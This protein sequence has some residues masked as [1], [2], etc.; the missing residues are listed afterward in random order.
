MSKRI[1]TKWFLLREE[2]EV[3]KHL[4]L[5]E[6]FKLHINIGDT[7][8]A[9]V[10]LRRYHRLNKWS[11]GW[12]RLESKYL[13]NL[14]NYLVDSFEFI[15]DL[16]SYLKEYE[17]RENYE[18]CAVLRDLITLEV[19]DVNR[20]VTTHFKPSKEQIFSISTWA[21]IAN[22]INNKEQEDED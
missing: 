14:D 7:K 22:A 6:R 4:F 9:A 15:I 1:Y 12:I 10:D 5:R 3:T 19:L 18:L 17:L 20:V 2:N 8:K 16:S 13:T 21:F 11:D